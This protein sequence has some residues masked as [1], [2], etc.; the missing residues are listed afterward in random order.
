MLGVERTRG[1][2]PRVLSKEC[3]HVYSITDCFLY[4]IAVEEG[5]ECAKDQ[6]LS[7]I[8]KIKYHVLQMV[9]LRK[10]TSS[11]PRAFLDML[12]LYLLCIHIKISSA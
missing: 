3:H 9:E 11:V 10:N 6:L 1:S 2:V 5:W 4:C 12:Y 8:R 7:S